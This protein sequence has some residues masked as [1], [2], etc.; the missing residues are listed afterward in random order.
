MNN[1]EIEHN[2]TSPTA[3][4]EINEQKREKTAS[5]LSV[6]KKLKVHYD[7]ICLAYGAWRDFA[8]DVPTGVIKQ[9]A[10][11]RSLKNTLKRIEL[12]KSFRDFMLT[13]KDVSSPSF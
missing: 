11:N 13:G 8:F 2:N 10:I 5:S 1:N 6:H 4:I 12:G 7:F 9:G 3:D